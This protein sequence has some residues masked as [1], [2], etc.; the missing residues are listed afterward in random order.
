MA[1]VAMEQELMALRSF[2]SQVMQ[3]KFHLQAA[4]LGQIHRK[5]VLLSDQ[6]GA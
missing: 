6:A 2:L 1:V 5:L 3:L 4:E